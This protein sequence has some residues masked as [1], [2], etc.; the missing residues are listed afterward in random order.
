MYQ[1]LSSLLR[2]LFGSKNMSVDCGR[3]TGQKTG[4]SYLK[5]HRHFRNFLF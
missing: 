4:S 3:Q 2:R 5:W 1:K